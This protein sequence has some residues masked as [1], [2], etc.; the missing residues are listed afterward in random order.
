MKFCSGLSEGKTGGKMPFFGMVYVGSSTDSHPRELAMG[1]L[2]P[3]S[4]HSIHI[5]LGAW[6]SGCSWKAVVEVRF[7]D[8]RESKRLP[9]FISALSKP[10]PSILLITP[11]MGSPLF[12]RNLSHSPS[13][14]TCALHRVQIS[15][16]SSVSNLRPFH[17][18][19]K[20]LSQW[21]FF[22]PLEKALVC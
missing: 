18:E 19:G 16:K 13:M 4:A 1:I 7:G 21:H 14:I 8:C 17:L 9:H 6:H 20:M 2:I 10:R 3:G 12:W 22:F 15:A 5:V 11:F